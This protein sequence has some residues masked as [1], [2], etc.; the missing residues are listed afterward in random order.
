MSEPIS[1]DMPGVDLEDLA[2][3]VAKAAMNL[4]TA[5][6]QLHAAQ[7]SVCDYEKIYKHT[8]S[9]LDTALTDLDL[10]ETP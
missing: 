4:R 2:K 6:S 3:K 5:K 1:I 7:A 10:P 9:A 8:R